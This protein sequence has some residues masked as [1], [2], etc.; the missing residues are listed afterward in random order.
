LAIVAWRGLVDR[1]TGKKQAVWFAI[2]LLVAGNVLASVANSWDL[3]EMLL[4]VTLFGHA[5][6]SL[7]EKVVCAEE[8]ALAIA[9]LQ[10]A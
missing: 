3:I 1:T 8:E 7:Q 10:D 6:W 5:L 9:V 4:M 2:A